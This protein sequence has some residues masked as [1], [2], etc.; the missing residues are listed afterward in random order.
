MKVSALAVQ[1]RHLRHRVPLPDDPLGRDRRFDARQFVD[2]EP[3]AGAAQRLLV[4]SPRPGTD[5]AEKMELLRVVGTQELTPA[6]S[7]EA[8]LRAGR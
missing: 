7:N 6:P 1:Q 2:V 4:Y 8:S 3:R 5:A